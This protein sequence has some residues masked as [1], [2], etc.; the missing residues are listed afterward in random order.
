MAEIVT[1]P[2]SL[3]DNQLPPHDDKSDTEHEDSVRQEETSGTSNGDLNLEE[4]TPAHAEAA[5]EVPVKV[6]NNNKE[7]A[8]TKKIGPVSVVPPKKA[9]GGPPTPTVKK[10]INSGTFGAGSVKSAG[11]KPTT[12]AASVPPSKV[13]APA[14]RKALTTNPLAAKPTSSASSKPPAPSTTT[15][16]RAS[17]APTR[18]IASPPVK[19]SLSASTSAKPSDAPVRST[20][21]SPTGSVASAST[22]GASAAPTARPR[23]SVSESVKKTPPSSRPSVVSS[24]KPPVTARSSTTSRS[25]TA[26][27]A[28]PPSRTAGSISSIKEVKEDTKAL[29]DLRTQLAETTQSFQSKNAQVFELENQ[30]ETL[31]QALDI[32]LKEIESKDTS[33][34]ES[35]LAR[36]DAESQLMEYQKMLSDVQKSLQELTITMDTKN[37]QLEAANSTISSQNT[38]IESLKAEVQELKDNL[39]AFEKKLESL[40]QSNALSSTAATEAAL[41]EH[42]ALVTAQAN[43]KAVT[44]EVEALKVTHTKAMQDSESQIAELREQ[45]AATEALQAQVASLKAEKE[46]NANKLSELEVEILESREVLENLED[47]RDALQ[48]QITMLEGQLA[49]LTTAVDAANESAKQSNASHAEELAALVK[50]HQAELD[51]RSESYKALENSL[52]DL[53]M[54]LLEATAAKEQAEKG[55]LESEASHAKKMAELQELHAAQQASLTADIEKISEELK[56]QETFYNA[57]VEVVKNEHVKLLQEAFERAKDEAARAHSEELKVFRANADIT[58]AQL[59]QAN[60]ES[61]N[62]LKSEHQSLMDSEINALKKQIST[63]NLELKATQDDLFKAKAAVETSNSEIETLTQQRDTARS[64]AEAAASLSPEHANEISRLTKELSNTKD[65][66]AA[67]TDML[68]L[69]RSSMTELSEKH[70]KELEEAAKSR[71]DEV[72]KLREA[73]DAE[74]NTLAKQ[75][76]DLLVRLSDLEGELAT[77]KASL[78]ARQTSSPK[79]SGNGTIPAS[80]SGITKEELIK[81]HEA[82][83][84]KVYDLQAEHEKAMKLAR[85]EVESA[86]VKV[87]ELQQDIARKAM[88]I[89]YLEQEQEE[90]SEQITRLKED[91]ERLGQVESKS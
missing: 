1:I 89:Q 48:K 32:K 80:N 35:E 90:S 22:K 43:L 42:E 23:A 12:S 60:Q 3:H 50:R 7:G 16:R 18:T 58:V 87:S 20:V 78:E 36:K 34:T 73:H 2:E 4:V 77:A 84:L 14:M 6:V 62:N 13:A 28:K 27:P 25:S 5:A 26:A 15:A 17:V 31:K 63:L 67:M 29:D 55:I 56:N 24:V 38:L 91:L 9:N 51:T 68:N 21:A 85:D 76:S 65:D 49:T 70:V 82:H 40:E 72:L 57:K 54:T 79:N 66:L 47:T 45:L 53:K 37:E 33:M 64:Q 86:L 11:T 30:I 44:E 74:V 88:E 19:S 52:E 83:N 75:K 61:I 41:I 81:M 59:Q 69:T 8:G 10:I 39:A 46:D 71:A